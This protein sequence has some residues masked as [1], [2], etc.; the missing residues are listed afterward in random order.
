LDFRIRHGEPNP[1][2]TQI[3]LGDISSDGF[4][5][6]QI[7]VRP[8]EIAEIGR[9]WK[10]FPPHDQLPE[11]YPEPTPATPAQ[12]S[13]YLAADM[14]LVLVLP[15]LAHFPNIAGVSVA[16]LVSG[17][18]ITVAAAIHSTSG[19]TATI[20]GPHEY[21][22]PL[23]TLEPG[24]YRLQFDLERSNDFNSST[25]FT[26]GYVHFTVHAAAV[27]EPA[28]WMM[29]AGAMGTLVLGRWFSKAA[30]APRVPAAN[31]KAVA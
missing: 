8:L 28:T 25:S 30:R 29:C 21:L 19:Y 16:H 22:Y 1:F 26:T 17:R 31:S 3:D 10:F 5:G 18:E 14:P 9:S 12:S 24:E 23:G 4:G 13:V 11:W 15:Q 2:P 6:R 27:P 20:Y 7:L